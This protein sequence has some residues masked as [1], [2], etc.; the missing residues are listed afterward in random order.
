MR[1]FFW[2]IV[3][4]VGFLLPRVA[5]AHFSAPI[6]LERV[7][8]KSDL[9]V[10]GRVTKVEGPI[11]GKMRGF[12]QVDRVLKGQLQA[13][14]VEMDFVDFNPV[15]S[16]NRP[17][18]ILTPQDYALFFFKKEG[19]Q[20]VA[21][22][23]YHLKFPVRESNPV[24][25][26][27]NSNASEA[28]RSELLW[29]LTSEPRFSVED[30]AT[31]GME[32]QIRE[33]MHKQHQSLPPGVGLRIAG[34]PDVAPLNVRAVEQL[35][36]FPPDE[37]TNKRLKELLSSPNIDANFRGRII[38]ALLHQNQP[39]A[40]AP[41]VEYIQ[42]NAESKDFV[43]QEATRNIRS[44]LSLI[45]DPAGFS[46]LVPLISHPDA[47][48]RASAIIAM[49]RLIQELKFPSLAQG[50][51][52]QAAGTSPSDQN[53]TR[54]EQL[55]ARQ[56]AYQVVPRLIPLLD[57]PDTQ[58]RFQ[59]ILALTEITSQP[60]KG[61]GYVPWDKNYKR[62]DEEPYIAYWKSWWAQQLLKAK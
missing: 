1:R 15:N 54:K 48:V 37:I 58:V 32:A 24:V 36:D 62:S 11:A 33:S 19:D 50:N 16:M 25:A 42:N 5:Y 4:V 43:V 29:S 57:D 39:Q 9:I 12:I 55:T 53:G 7:A 41:A 47:N 45:H 2:G 14:E 38:E 52:V 22:D 28:V 17:P 23:S 35:R 44:S 34:R 56:A 49:A 3:I 8:E 59:T 30:Q 10:R 18:D 46:D 31:K 26:Q 13:N 40:L 21:F 27:P 51:V 60:G 20:F 61:P 6:G